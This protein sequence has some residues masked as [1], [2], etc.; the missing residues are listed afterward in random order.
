MTVFNQPPLLGSDCS[1]EGK[2]ANNE[3]GSARPTP[4]P[5]I[6]STGARLTPLVEV[7]PNN[8][9]TM[10]PVHEK[11]TIT[12]VRAIK[13]IPISPPFPAFS[14]VLF[15]QLLGSVISNAPK[16]EIANNDEDGKEQEVGNRMR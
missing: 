2:N 5:S 12:N 7:C 16:N 9:P 6:P 10:G 11:L 8:V 3:N 4:K 14:S 1:I 15:A 13:K